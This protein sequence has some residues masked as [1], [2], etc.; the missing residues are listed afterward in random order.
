MIIEVL[1]YSERGIFNS[2]VFCFRE[3]PEKI[4]VFLKTLEIKDETIYEQEVKYTFLVEQS[5]S[6]FGSS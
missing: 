5:F 2:F 1:G 3:H 4:D 6:D